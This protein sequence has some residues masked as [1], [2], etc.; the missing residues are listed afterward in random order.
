M[1]TPPRVAVNHNVLTWARL[2]SGYTVERIAR[3][4]QVSEDRVRAWEEGVRTPTVRQ[5]QLLANFLHRPLG[6]FFMAQPPDVAPLATEYRRLRG[7]RP[8]DESPELRLALRQMLIRRERALSLMDELGEPVPDFALRAHLRD[9]PTDVAGRLRAALG[10]D[11]GTQLGWASQWAAWSGWRAAVERIGVLVFQFP[12]VPLEEVRGL[13]LLRRPL[14]VTAINGKEIPEAKAFT[15]IHEVVHLMLAA[16][17]EEAPAFSETRSEDEWTSVEEFA[18]SVAG[19]VLLPDDVLRAQVL[20]L[21]RQ[22]AA[23][24][25]DDVRRLARRFKLTPLA[26]AARLRVSGFMNWSEYRAWKALWDDYVATLPPRRGGFASPVDRTLGR[27]GRPF[28]QLVLEAMDA[29]RITSVDAS[30]YLDLRFGHFD[31]LRAH[32]ADQG[33]GAGL[34]E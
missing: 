8:G 3:R 30:R 9:S 23:W 17:H 13:A 2:Q 29:N 11:I 16:A 20:G 15:V 27:A 4:L 22:S 18:E 14:P 12:K 24:G 19:Q 31:D 21:Q 28:A 25:L 7:V 32:L 26:T 6:V 10:V 34:D 1:P 5:L 33:A